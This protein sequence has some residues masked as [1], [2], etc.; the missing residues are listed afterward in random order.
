MILLT[1]SQVINFILS[2]AGGGQVMT[3][4]KIVSVILDDE[5][6]NKIIQVQKD[7]ND[8]SRSSVLNKLGST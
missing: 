3:D 6:L 4:K 5:T 2:Y 7:T 8:F 1:H